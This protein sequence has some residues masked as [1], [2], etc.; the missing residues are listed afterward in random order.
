MMR[1]IAPCWG[2]GYCLLPRHIGRCSA[3]LLRVRSGG[4]RP[5]T[6][7]PCVG[8]ACLCGGMQLPVGW[9]LN[10]KSATAHGRASLLLNWRGGGGLRF[11]GVARSRGISI[12]R[13]L[14]D[15]IGAAPRFADGGLLYLRAVNLRRAVIVRAGIVMVGVGTFG[16]SWRHIQLRLRLMKRSAGAPRFEGLAPSRR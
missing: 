10:T 2:L 5:K 4:Q 6:P 15:R 3:P 16:N 8:R 11:A 9:A 14:H 7:S 12:W 1:G 13:W